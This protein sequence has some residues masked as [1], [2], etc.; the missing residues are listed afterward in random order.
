MRLK[1]CKK[2]KKRLHKRV[3]IERAEFAQEPNDGVVLVLSDPLYLLCSKHA[4]I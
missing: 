3:K 2:K 4:S 1:R